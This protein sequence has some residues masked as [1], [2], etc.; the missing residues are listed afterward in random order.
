[1]TPTQTEATNNL[2]EIVRGIA[3]RTHKTG[4]YR[5][6]GN[7]KHNSKAALVD[8]TFNAVDRE[9]GATIVTLTANVITARG[10]IINPRV[11]PV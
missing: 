2:L 3:K 6:E 1:M 7:W 4:T 11:I 8:A 10:R 9:T 5:L